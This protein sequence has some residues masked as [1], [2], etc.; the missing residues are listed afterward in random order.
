MAIRRL[1]I[2]SNELVMPDAYPPASATLLESF[3]TKDMAD[4]VRESWARG[5][6]GLNKHTTHCI[7]VYRIP[8]TSYYAI[9]MEPREEGK[10]NGYQG[11]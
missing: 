5:L 11:T 6:R 2:R 4:S 9:Y 10:G 3:P 1:L 8:G 7:A